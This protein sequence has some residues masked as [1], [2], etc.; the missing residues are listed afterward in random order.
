MRKVIVTISVFMIVIL[1]IITIYRVGDLEKRYVNGFFIFRSQE[2]QKYEN[3][4]TFNVGYKIVDIQYKDETGKLQ[5]MTTAIWYTTDKKTNEYAYQTVKDK[6]RLGKILSRVAV[7]APVKKSSEKYPLL[8]FL[9]GGYICGT[10]SLF[11]TEYL[12]S[13]GFIVAAPDFHDDAYLCRIKGGRYDSLLTVLEKLKKFRSADASTSIRLLS[14][15]QRVPGTSRVID[16]LL[17]FN[18]DSKSL[19]FE[20]IEEN[21]I[22][23]IGHSYG[24]RTILGLIGAHPQK[25]MLDKR[26]KSAVILSGAVFPFEDTLNNIKIPVMIMQ[27]DDIDDVDTHSIP[28]RKVFD[29]AMPPKFFLRLKNGLHGS[30]YN[31]ICDKYSDINKCQKSSEFAKVIN[32]YSLAFFNRYLKNDL[33]GEI[34]LNTQSP[35]LKSYEKEFD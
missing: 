17:E 29:D 6:L 12:A 21:S 35:I 11:L 8:M 19:F 18:K 2:N 25:E 31:G 34:L 20:T 27:G 26:I 30:F 15:H 14:E 22:G 33:N 3:I 23:V 16:K 10:E 1:L 9:H 4:G 7:D 28:R 24:G 5:T 13:N 32:S